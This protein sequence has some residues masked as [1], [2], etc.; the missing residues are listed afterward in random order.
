MEPSLSH[1]LRLCKET[2]CK[3]TVNLAAVTVKRKTD[4]PEG[5]T[6]LTIRGAASLATF[7]GGRSSPS[8][9]NSERFYATESLSLASN[10]L[11]LASDTAGGCREALPWRRE[12]WAWAPPLSRFRP[13]QQ[14]LSVGPKLNRRCVVWLDRSVPFGLSLLG[15]ALVPRD[16]GALGRSDCGECAVCCPSM[17]RGERAVVL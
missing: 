16:T 6:R 8:A 5:S 7:G 12:I 13:A 11:R 3:G 9:G 10:Q 1:Q 2:S 4:L 17:R 15:S 14:P